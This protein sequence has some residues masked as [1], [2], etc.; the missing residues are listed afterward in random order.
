MP[1]FTE[2]LLSDL[3][4]DLARDAEAERARLAAEQAA[5]LAAEAETARRAEEA[6]R[7]EMTARLEAENR[8]RALA[9]DIRHARIESSLPHS[10]TAAVP[11]TASRGAASRGAS[12]ETRGA[13][14]NPPLDSVQPTPPG[15]HRG[16]GFYFVVMGLPMICLTAVAVVWLL[17]APPPAAL[18]APPPTQLSIGADPMP[19]PQMPEVAAPGA[20]VDAPVQ[21]VAAALDVPGPARAHSEATA[22]ATADT[23]AG[24][25]GRR[26]ARPS[27][28]RP[29]APKPDAPKPVRLFGGS[30]M[31]DIMGAE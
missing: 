11:G 19:P 15:A 3:K 5:R 1:A 18:P 17:R 20:E 12:P 6:R 21:P 22:E 30:S 9:H 23:P 27:P 24:R 28:P 7:A 26:A 29:D 31:T 13:H 4:Q 8:R 2:D 25:T 14:A 16:A 10:P